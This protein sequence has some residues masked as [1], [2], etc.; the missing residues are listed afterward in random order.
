MNEK[1]Q[2]EAPPVIEINV[3][4]CKGCAIC[5]DFCPQDVLAIENGV[6]V[7]VNLDPCNRCQLCDYR[8]PDFAITVK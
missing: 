2:Q 3:A 8:C 6:A 7:V 5:V 1:T 4:W